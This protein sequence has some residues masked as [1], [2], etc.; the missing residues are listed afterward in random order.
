[1][2]L[3]RSI[4]LIFLIIFSHQSWTKADDIRDFEIEGMS[5][6]DSLLDFFSK[7]EIENKRK[8]FKNSKG[9]VK[10]YS[11]INMSDGNFKTYNKVAFYFKS[12]DSQY[13][14]QSLT[15]RNYYVNNIEDCHELQNTIIKEI[16][17]LAPSAQK[18]DKGTYKHR[19][20]A[21][22]LSIVRATNFLFSDN[23]VIHI[24]CYDFS[25]EREKK[26][27]DRLSVS[28][29]SSDYVDFQTNKAYK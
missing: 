25:K 18:I 2:N 27:R 8:Y 13:I 28:I 23:S 17:N 10:E 16:S 14:I 24:G 29:G 15:G 7:K 1:M 4:I 11:K 19:A 3:N 20:D 21:T 12:N 6:G 22:G 9:P 26:S 5:I